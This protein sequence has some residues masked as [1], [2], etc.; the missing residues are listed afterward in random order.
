MNET[1]EEL[2]LRER[3]MPYG[4]HRCE[5]AQSEVSRYFTGV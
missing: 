3:Y 2:S 5:R 4:T 1:L